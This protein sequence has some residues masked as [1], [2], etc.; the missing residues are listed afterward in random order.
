MSRLL[1]VDTSDRLPGLLPLHG[2]SALVSS[3][4]VLVSSTDHPFVGDL[5]MADLPV[6]VLGRDRVQ[7]M[8]GLDLLAA[9]GDPE[10]AAWGRAVADRVEETGG[11][12]AWLRGP[13]DGDAD[14]HAMAME[15][16]QRSLEVEVVY[17]GAEPRGA[18][19]LDLVGVMARL[20][21]PGG[22][23][24]DREQDHASLGAYAVEEVYELLEAIHSGD[25]EA[26][27]EELGD[28]LL[29]VV[30]HAQIATD[31]ATFD[32]DDV[33]RGIADKLVRRHPHVFADGD[34]RTPDQVSLRW[35]E[36]KAEEKPDRDGPFDGVPT[37]LPALQ[38][39]EKYQR[40]AARA[41]VDDV[42]PGQAAAG[43]RDALAAVQ[44]GSDSSRTAGVGDLL[45]AVVALARAY[46]VDP[47]AALRGSAHRYRERVE[48]AVSAAPDAPRGHTGG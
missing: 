5:E 38:L 43:V 8:A 45:A 7:S 25:P 10:R 21:G 12:V 32:V 40:R 11:D 19:L 34:A 23:P 3:D 15:A 14:L 22:C 35:D 18:A 24:W 37:A 17:F 20:R 31:D 29:Q 46:D 39:V 42:D 26:V 4:L 28:V 13:G 16:A 36:L 30:F 1:L 47:E 44:D 2:W 9:G 27:R 6:E 48:A 33:A 41:G